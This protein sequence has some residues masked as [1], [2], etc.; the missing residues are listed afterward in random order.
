FDERITE[1]RSFVR[2]A[3]TMFALAIWPMLAEAQGT[4]PTKTV[5]FIVPFPAGGI[6]DV[7]ARIVG[8]KLQVKWGHPIIIEQR[9]GAGGNIGADLTA[10]ADPDGYTLMLAPPGPLA[11][12]S[13]LYKKLSYRPDAFVPIT[14]IG[15][16]PNVAIVKK[17]LPANSLK[18]LV[19]LIKKNP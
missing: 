17:E 12:N 8:D 9:T 18:E 2:V 3:I 4:F 19:E 11:V 6:N 16:V 14:V 7:L 10:Q 13:S 15:S 1:M 5:K